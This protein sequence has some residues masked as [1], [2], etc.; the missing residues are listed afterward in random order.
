[1]KTPYLLQILTHKWFIVLA[2]IKVQKVHKFPLW[3]LLIHDW[4]KF[5]PIEFVTYR[6]R[7]TGKPYSKEAW[8]EAKQHHYQHNPH[9]YQYWIRDEIPTPMPDIYITE[10]V[11]D[12]MAAGRSYQGSW[13]IQAWLRENHTYIVVH[14]ET[15]QKLKPLL[16]T[17]GFTWPED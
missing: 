2:G 17:L 15:K 14:E 6:K 5:L 7:F 4:T 3:R 11:I 1:L 9:H 8:K 13:N 12:W 10:M 16:Q